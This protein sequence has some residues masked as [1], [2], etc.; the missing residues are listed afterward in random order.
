[1]RN[2]LVAA[3]YG[4]ALGGAALASSA[5]ASVI[6]SFGSSS[7]A[8]GPT[9]LGEM[10]P[11]T[12]PPPPEGTNMLTD[13]GMH[14]ASGEVVVGLQVD[15]NG[16]EPGGGTS[17]NSVFSFEAMSL[18]YEVSQF[19]G[20]WVHQ[21][22][23][24]GEFVFTESGSG[25]EVLRIVFD[26]ALFTSFVEF[27][28]DGSGQFEMGRSATLQSNEGADPSLSFIAGAPL[29]ALG[30]TDL[31]VGEAFGF[32]LSDIV[33]LDHPSLPLHLMGD[34]GGWFHHWMA[35]GSFVASASAVPAP[36]ALAL[37]LCS[38]VVGLT[39]RRRVA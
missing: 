9:F 10:A 1:M 6:F 7:N 20:G 16:H 13:G 2:G 12:E 30:I 25:V 3:L 32:A 14:D 27:G 23:M 22:T 19:G 15:A 28:D 31:S 8:D 38:I 34:S 33:A 24:D 39:R 36:G 11:M 26:N 29:I 37:L 17:F 5:N 21:W 4:G 18:D 35:E